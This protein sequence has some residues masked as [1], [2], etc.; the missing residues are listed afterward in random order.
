MGEEVLDIVK[1]LIGLA[2]ASGRYVGIFT[3]DGTEARTLLEMGA[4]LV[5]PGNDVGLIKAE[6][7]G[8]IAQ[9]RQ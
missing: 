2:H 6:A 5:T 9:A 3:R 4:D 8:R 1:R 7:V